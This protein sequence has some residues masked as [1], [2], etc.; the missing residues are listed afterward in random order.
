MCIADITDTRLQQNSIVN[1]DTQLVA[2]ALA[3]CLLS[4]DALV[5]A[6]S[7]DENSAI[8]RSMPDITWRGHDR[9]T[10]QAS[11]TQ[12]VMRQFIQSSI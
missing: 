1:N 12:T 3:F 5:V 10:H 7:L 11:P 6:S 2:T 4:L 9:S 8:C